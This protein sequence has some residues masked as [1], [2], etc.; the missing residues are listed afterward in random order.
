MSKLRSSRCGTS[1]PTH[2]VMLMAALGPTR[3][4]LE[5]TA[6]RAVEAAAN[7]VTAAE[8]G[9]NEAGANEVGAAEAEGERGGGG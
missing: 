3:R 4:T 2:R 6:A 9:A 5:A 1:A 8:A 7:E